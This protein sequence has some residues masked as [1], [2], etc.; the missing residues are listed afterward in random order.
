MNHQECR[1]A[2]VHHPP[3]HKRPQLLGHA[4]N[5]NEATMAFHRQLWRL[6]KQG[7]A[8]DVVLARCDADQTVILRQPLLAPI[9]RQSA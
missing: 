8:G 1:Y 2:I 5:P 7:R 4:L 3:G 9:K 6:R